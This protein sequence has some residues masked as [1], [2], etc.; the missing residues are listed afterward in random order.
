MSASADWIVHNVQFK[1][2]IALGTKFSFHRLESKGRS[3]HS[4]YSLST[5]EPLVCSLLASHPSDPA[6]DSLRH[7]LQRHPSSL[8]KLLGQQRESSR[9][10]KASSGEW[11]S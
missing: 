1:R 4:K 6:A 10:S 5:P 7:Y 11:M 2:K 3:A 8:W 9:T